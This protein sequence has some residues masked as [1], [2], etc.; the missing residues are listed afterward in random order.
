MTGKTSSEKDLVEKTG[1]TSDVAVEKENKSNGI[2]SPDE[3]HMDDGS[4]EEVGT[5]NDICTN[6]ET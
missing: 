6:S 5:K 2:Q 1:T 3:G 4:S